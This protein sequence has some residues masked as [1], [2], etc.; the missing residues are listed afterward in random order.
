MLTELAVWYLRKK[1][2]SVLINYE[3]NNGVVKCRNNESYLYDNILNNVEYRLS[4]DK[5]FVIPDGKF[6]VSTK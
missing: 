1:K 5:E 4:N 3:I 2:K 6:N